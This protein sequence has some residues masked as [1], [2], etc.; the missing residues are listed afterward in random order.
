M[1]ICFN[2]NYDNL[3]DLETKDGTWTYVDEK[4]KTKKNDSDVTL[5]KELENELLQLESNA[6]L[7]WGDTN[8]KIV[9]P[10]KET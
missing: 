8:K 2:E 7:N 9:K 3:L 6:E 10:R 1:T 5:D 4:Y